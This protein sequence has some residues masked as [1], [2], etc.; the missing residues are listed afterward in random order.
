M[1][2]SLSRDP[3]LVNTGTRDNG[4]ALGRP[5]APRESAASPGPEVRSAAGGGSERAA[6]PGPRKRRSTVRRRLLLGVPIAGGVALLALAL[7][8]GVGSSGSLGGLP[9]LTRG[10][11]AL[12]GLAEPLPGADQV[13]L[14]LRLWRGLTALGVGGALA[15]SGGLLQGVLRNDLAA[16]S[17]LGLTSGAALGATLAILVL[18]GLAP[19]RMFETLRGPGPLL[20]SACA[21]AGS[22]AVTAL[23]VVFATTAGR[24]SVPS[25]L[26]LGIAINTTVA[27]LLTAIQSVVLGDFQVTRA[28]LTWSFGT[29]DDR[30]P[31]HAALVW[32]GLLAALAC[33]PFLWRELDLFETGEEDARALG[34]GTLRVKFLAL[35]AASLAAALAVSVAGQIAFV[36][37]VVPHLLRLLVGRSHAVL[38]PLCAVGGGAF[39]LS[40]DLGQ[41]WLLAEAA[42]PP[43][44]IM[45]LVGGPLFFALLLKNRHS[46]RSL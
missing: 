38:L 21:F 13:I 39:L 12:I 27:G 22:L 5:M 30:L 10:L 45:S 4:Y 29:L 14:E 20:V 6:S 41:R 15:L 18:G 31:M 35:G 34:V 42:L 33:V 44:V 37:L 25:L 2:R 16:P 1:G 43:G 32:G 19:E 24:L 17:V 28:L 11:L 3:D 40:M 26:L 23:V 8:L 36:G 9:A 7:S 46:L